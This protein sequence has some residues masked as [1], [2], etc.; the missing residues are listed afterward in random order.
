MP[1][2]VHGQ[3][4]TTPAQDELMKGALSELLD[5]IDEI[6]AM[7]LEDMDLDESLRKLLIGD[8]CHAYHALPMMS[9]VSKAGQ[10][11]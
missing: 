8:S 4:T 5:T 10:T 1:A 3:L 6:V 7:K 11:L 9:E 2:R